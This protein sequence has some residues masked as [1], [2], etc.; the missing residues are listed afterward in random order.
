MNDVVD[1]RG[2]GWVEC[3]CMTGEWSR[4]SRGHDEL[5]NLS[6]NLFRDLSIG[7]LIAID[8]ARCDCT[9]LILQLQYSN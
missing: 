5:F 4:N 3:A 2:R 8:C 6:K 1:F 7:I 9:I